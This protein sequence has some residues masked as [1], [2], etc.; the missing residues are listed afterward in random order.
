MSD[1]RGNLIPIEF[2]EDFSGFDVRFDVKRCFLIFPKTSET[3]GQHAHRWVEQV[4]IC[5]DGSFDVLLKDGKGEEQSIS[6]KEPDTGLLI[7][8]LVWNEMFN[9]SENC[10]ILV[11]ASDHY[12]AEEYINDFNELKAIVSAKERL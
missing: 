3:R 12:D 9:F 5:L 7:P 8:K 1:H 6:L 4:L 2:G 11:L 10:K